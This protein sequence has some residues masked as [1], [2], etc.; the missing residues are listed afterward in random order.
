MT[1]E[2][3]NLL[4]QIAKAKQVSRE[5]VLE[6]PALGEALDYFAKHEGV[7]VFAVPAFPGKLFAT[8][9]ALAPGRCS[10]VVANGKVG[11]QLEGAVDPSHAA[12]QPEIRRVFKTSEERYVLGVVLTPETV[13]SQGDIYS[14][15]EVR[16]AAHDYM[17]HAGALGKQHGEIVT[18][19]LKIL[20]S[21]VSPADFTIEEETV[22][23]GT[24]LM[25]IRVVDDELWDGV[26]KGEFTGFSIGGQAYR[27][28]E[29]A[30]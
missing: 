29:E 13:D 2:R 15:D 17:E 24:W 16:K 3:F 5:W 23:K 12:E 22:A 14:H 18:G 6:I 20:E 30:A 25:G 10:V 11:T 4:Q 19:K 28:P 21:Y 7:S 26:K 1:A 8:N 27:K 9:K